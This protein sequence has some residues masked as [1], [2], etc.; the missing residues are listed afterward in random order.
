MNGEPHL[1]HGH[2]HRRFLFE[3]PKQPGAP[4]HYKFDSES[5]GYWLGY[6]GVAESYAERIGP[7]AARGWESY[8][9][10]TLAA[11]DAYKSKA[12]AEAAWI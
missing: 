9:E 12:T 6:V 2:T 11:V 10:E 1:P 3:P 7:A 5:H 8:W 4:A